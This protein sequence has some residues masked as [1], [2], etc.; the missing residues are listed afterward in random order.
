M[1][2]EIEDYSPNQYFTKY[3]EVN[4]TQTVAVLNN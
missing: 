3:S 4:S 2:I 1:D